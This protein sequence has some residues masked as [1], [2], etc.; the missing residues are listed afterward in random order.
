MGAAT[1]LFA[2]PHVALERRG[3]G[4]LVFR[5]TDELGPYPASMAHSFRAGAD[6]H[7][8][9]VLAA[10]RPP[11]SEE[12]IEL[13]WGDARARADSVAQAFLDL[14]LGP[15][16]PLLVLSGNSLA[17]LT[18]MLAAFTAGVPIVPVSVA[19]SLMSRDHARLQA[20][21]ELCTPGLVFAESAE[22][23]GQ[24]LAGV[25]SAGPEIAVSASVDE[26]AATVPGPEVDR[27]FAAVGED[28][29]AKILFTSGSTGAPK[30]VVN[31]HRMLCSNQQMLAQ[32]WPFVLDEPPVLVDWLPWSHTFAGN[33]DT[34][35]VLARGGTYYIDDGKPAPVLFERTA[36]ALRAI[37][38]TMYLNVP[39]GWALLL[40]RLESDAELAATFFSRLRFMFYA[41]A[42][43]PQSL[44]DRL[45]AVADSL[46]HEDIPLT[47]SWGATETA[48]A[49]TSAHFASARCGCIGVPLAGTAVKLVPDGAKREI[50]VAGPNVTP[51][52]LRN[53]EATAA[54][55]DEEGYYRTGDAARL[56]DDEDPSQGLMFDGRLAED[57]KL[58]SGTWVRVGALRGA[59]VSAAGVLSDAVIAG[60]DRE[61]ATALCWL[62]P[63]AADGADVDDRLAAAL[64]ELNAAAGSAARIER[65]LLLPDPPSLDAG[66]ITDKG[67]VN[68]RAVLE[69]RAGEVALL[70]AEP[71]DPRVITPAGPRRSG[72]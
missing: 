50:R 69:R 1:S 31:T 4:T 3:D 30:G 39:A 7:P 51:G 63:G 35:L 16:R 22:V 11:G 62:A 10:Q 64:A 55:F 33:H 28:T 13:T 27:A 20:I 43:L 65:L 37:G 19:Y 25:A 60:H 67:Y 24:A 18:L 34:G 14:G 21:A 66:E 57:F 36:S 56:V 42:A 70:Y 29:V 38:P 12:W 47:A 44:W 68:Q 58:T 61:Y 59:L 17:H 23:F 15:E 52:Y 54:A 5:S 32:A 9:R 53:P 6:R 41:G 40:S 72:R 45:R 2:P 49:V 8:D 26:L 46:G 71:C 48:P